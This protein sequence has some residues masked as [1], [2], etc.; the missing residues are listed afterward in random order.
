MRVC[1][2]RGPVACLPASAFSQF[3]ATRP[4]ARTL[5]PAPPSPTIYIHCSI[6]VALAPLRPAASFCLFR[7]SFSAGLLLLGSPKA[8]QPRL[9]TTACNPFN[10][11]VFSIQ[12]LRPPH[13]PSLLPL[14]NFWCQSIL[15]SSQL[16]SPIAQSARPFGN[17]SI[18]PP[19]YSFWVSHHLRQ[20]LTLSVYYSYR[21]N[22]ATCEKI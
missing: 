10:K 19:P 16:L 1:A 3:S 2:L 6:P 18:P 15:S 22:C 7:T 17:S 9:I 8:G 20:H 4:D 14:F 5:R 21:C 11:R 12:T 13:P